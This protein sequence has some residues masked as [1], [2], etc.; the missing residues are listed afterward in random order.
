MD[1]FEAIRDANFEVREVISACIDKGYLGIS[2]NLR[3][4]FHRA[5]NIIRSYFGNTLSDQ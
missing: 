1:N 3:Q 2:K 4:Y 5:I